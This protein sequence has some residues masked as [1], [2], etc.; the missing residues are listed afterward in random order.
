MRHLIVGGTGTLGTEL[1]RQLLAI[2]GNRVVCFSRCEMKQKQLAKAL[3]NPAGLDFILGDIRDPS[4]IDRACEGMHTVFHVAA[5]KHVDTGQRFV[6]EFAKT[7]LIGTFNVA[8]AARAAGVKFVVFSST[9][10]AVDPISAYGA[11]KLASEVFLYSQNSGSGTRFSVY[12]WG[13]VLGSNG[14]FIPELIEQIQRTGSYRLTHPEMTRFWIPIRDAVKFLLK[15]Y[16]T[17]PSD[18][19]LIPPIRAAK[20]SRVAETIA[21]LIGVK[22]R[23]PEI[24]GLRPGEKLH[25]VLS[26]AHTAL[27]V[28]SSK[29]PGLQ[30]TDP[31]LRSLL[32]TFMG[33]SEIRRPKSEP[34]AYRASANGRHAEASV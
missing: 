21:D 29:D 7:D 12:R 23:A 1:A 30:M 10:K 19:A 15:S 27:P 32:L 28:I 18:R 17:A 13:N 33:E 9:D 16:R 3:G 4:A 34:R 8:H 22:L 24:C 6:E 31:E 25:E 2:P 5:L 14:S 26:S 20:L 11:L